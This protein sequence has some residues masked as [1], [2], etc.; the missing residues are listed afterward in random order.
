MTTGAS[1]GKLKSRILLRAIMTMGLC[2]NKV[3]YNN[4]ISRCHWLLRRF[5]GSFFMKWLPD[6]KGEHSRKLIAKVA[7]FHIPSQFFLIDPIIGN[8]SYLQAMNR[9]TWISRV[10]KDKKAIRQK[11]TANEIT[12]LCFCLISKQFP[13][14]NFEIFDKI[15]ADFV[16]TEMSGNTRKWNDFANMEDFYLHAKLNK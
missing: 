11:Y 16:Q 2:S 10:N 15:F 4:R 7:W 13:W 3:D 8:D 14:I 12:R 6:D 9:S 1:P 5:W